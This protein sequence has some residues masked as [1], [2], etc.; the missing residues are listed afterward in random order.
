MFW[1]PAADDSSN[2]RRDQGGGKEGAPALVQGLP[3]RCVED[4]LQK[5]ERRAVPI[6]EALPFYVASTQA[7]TLAASTSGRW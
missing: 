3:R 1:S 6:R 7:P 5:K 2:R 4:K